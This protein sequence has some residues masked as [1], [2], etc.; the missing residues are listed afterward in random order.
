MNNVVEEDKNIDFKIISSREIE[1]IREPVALY[2]D[3]NETNYHKANILGVSLYNEKIHY[4]IPADSLDNLS[5][6]QGEVYTY[7]AKKNYVLLKKSQMSVLNVSMDVMIASYLL[8]Y[9]KLNFL[10]LSLTIPYTF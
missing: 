9:N 6:I 3:I 4:Y 2:I 1:E 10:Q 8:N 7:D 5:F